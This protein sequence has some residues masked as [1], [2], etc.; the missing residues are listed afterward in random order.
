MQRNKIKNDEWGVTGNLPG[1]TNAERVLVNLLEGRGR[2]GRIV[3]KW[4]LQ[5]YD[6]V[7]RTGFLNG[8]KC[9]GLVNKVMNQQV[10]QNENFSD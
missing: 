1:G 6:D 9:Q 5:K 4:I 7:A 10:A 8:K 2:D 3:L